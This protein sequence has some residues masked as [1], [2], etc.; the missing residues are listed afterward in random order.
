MRLGRQEQPVGERLAADGDRVQ[1][2]DD[3]WV[4]AGVVVRPIAKVQAVRRPVGRQDGDDPGER[5]VRVARA[6]PGVAD[7]RSGGARHIVER[8]HRRCVEDR[9]GQERGEVEALDVAGG[10]GV[11][12]SVRHRIARGDLRRRPDPRHSVD[13][14]DRLAEQ[15]PADRQACAAG[16]GSRRAVGRQVG[17]RQDVGRSGDA[18]G[19]H[20]SLVDE[21]LARR[22]III[23]FLLH[24]GA[25]DDRAG[26]PAKG[27]QGRGQRPAG[28]RRGDRAAAQLA[29][30]EAPRNQLVRHGEPDRRRAVGAVLDAHRDV[31]RL[32]SGGR[33]AGVV[34]ADGQR[35]RESQVEMLAVG[36]DVG[37]QQVPQREEVGDLEVDR[38]LEDVARL[39]RAG[40]RQV[41]HAL[42]DGDRLGGQDVRGC[43]AVD[44]DRWLQRV[45]RRPGPLCLGLVRQ[46]GESG[47]GQVQDRAR[48]GVVAR[49]VEGELHRGV[50]RAAGAD[51]LVEVPGQRAAGGRREGRRGRRRGRRAVGRRSAE[52]DELNPRRQLVG[53]VEARDR[54]SG[55]DHRRD[56]VVLQKIRAGGRL[57][58]RAE[59]RRRHLD[60]RGGDRRRRLSADHAGID[61]RVV[62]RV[63]AVAEAPLRLDGQRRAERRVAAQVGRDVHDGLRLPGRDAAE[64]KQQD[65]QLIAGRPRDDDG[66]AR[67]ILGERVRGVAG[68]VERQDRRGDRRAEVRRRRERRPVVATGT[69]GRQ[70]QVDVRAVPRLR[71]RPIHEPDRE[72][73]RGADQDLRW[74]GQ[75]RGRHG[76]RQ[77]DAAL[78]FLD[79]QTSVGKRL[80]GLP[81]MSVRDDRVNFRIPLHSA[82]PCLDWPR[83]R[84]TGQT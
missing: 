56:E 67:A 77:E 31:A 60:Q 52:R 36:E 63:V 69:G 5:A 15:P 68:A 40:V 78:Q 25:E 47:G 64:G 12:K 66:V 20:V 71:R 51:D 53:Q 70:F 81:L 58:L 13:R 10:Q 16:V 45:Q 19:E 82:L 48:G 54:L 83:R 80:A 24:D 61:R 57:V 1:N 55:G 2:V 84:E 35:G 65:D 46:R 11:L 23:E 8:R 33:R 75:R 30:V 3:R 18:V 27:R 17:I 6:E 39:R 4:L 76:A 14:I 73:D 34:R 44:R 38:I 37:R 9:Q 72:I 62:E 74:Q 59:V 43:V 29:V 50:R 26:R 41:G 42:L 28:P 79:P 7:G 22:I 21:R 32:E 49:H